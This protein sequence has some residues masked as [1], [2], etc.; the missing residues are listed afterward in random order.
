MR[1][2]RPAPLHSL[3]AGLG[4]L[5]MTTSAATTAA[6]AGPNLSS[7]VA[8]ESAAQATTAPTATAKN[9]HSAAATNT[10]SA[11]QSNTDSAAPTNTDSAAPTNTA[12]TNTH[13][14]SA[15]ATDTGKTNSKGPTTTSVSANPTITGGISSSLSGNIPTITGT[16]TNSVGVPTNLPT[17]S[18]AFTI[19]APSVPPT[20]DAPYMHQ[21]TAPEGTIFIIAGAIIGFF[22]IAVIAWRAL[23]AYS[24]HQSIK[25][26]A[27]L[28][29]MPDSKAL[30]TTPVAPFY[31]YKDRE[32][33]IS[34]AGLGPKSGKKGP[35]RPP[36]G[37]GAAPLFFSPTAGA[38]GIPNPGN[39]GSNYLPSGYYA[40][41]A[42]QLG[43]G[44][45]MAHIG[46]GNSIS[47]SNL[48]PTRDGYGRARS[49]G[50]S[51]PGSPY[52]NAAQSSSTLNLS[53]PM[54]DRRAPSVYLDDLFD[55]ENAP[56]VPG[57]A[58]NPSGPRN[59]A[60]F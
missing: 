8:S 26:A 37:A 9:T 35:P 56:P 46:S 42:S 5:A 18:G 25:R 28:Q 58:R 59:P 20:A 23:M 2:Q 1:F 3:V 22:A 36:A 47:L 45:G 15:S 60:R 39:R 32:S 52:M 44:Q 34:L 57:H 13:S 27:M 19:V 6:D 51:E 53:Q 21:S 12:A 4:L 16:N 24:L 31:Q 10:D 7:L 41:G 30:F 50:T 40:A 48:G 11:A 29:N 55:S 14:A 38:G 49:I 54:G 33:T 17:L 43:N